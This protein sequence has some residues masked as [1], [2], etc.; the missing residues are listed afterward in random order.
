[1]VMVHKLN[2]I[3]DKFIVDIYIFLYYIVICPQ[4]QP[5]F[6]VILDANLLLQTVIMHL[7]TMI[8]AI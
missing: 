4:F 5:N 3:P 6:Q 7:L 2:I 8:Y 1:M